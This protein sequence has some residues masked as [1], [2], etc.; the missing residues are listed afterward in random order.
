[1]YFDL[2]TVRNKDYNKEILMKTV[3][4]AST[5]IVTVGTGPQQHVWH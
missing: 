2:Q 3:S 4:V 5:T 1:M